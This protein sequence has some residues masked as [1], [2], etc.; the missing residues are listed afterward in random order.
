MEAMQ[1][2]AATVTGIK[3][4][5]GAWATGKAFQGNENIQKK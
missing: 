5:L 2:K 4:K 1:V 3:K